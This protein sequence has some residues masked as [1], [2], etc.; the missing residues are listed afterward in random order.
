MEVEARVR[1]VTKDGFYR[2]IRQ[3]LSNPAWT[4][5]E[6]RES[7]AFTL[8]DRSR[9]SRVDRVEAGLAP[10][11]RFVGAPTAGLA[12]LP[13]VEPAGDG[14]DAGSWLEE[15]K[16]KERPEDITI[17]IVA[18][19][20]AAAAEAASEAAGSAGSGRREAAAAGDGR[21]DWR[22]L[23]RL[24]Q[25]RLQLSLEL[26]SSS[27]PP[28][29]DAVAGYEARCFTRLKRRWSFVHKGQVR[30]DVTQ[31]QEGRSMREA[32]SAAPNFEA[33]L[34]W[35]GPHSVKPREA[36]TKLLCKVADVMSL[37]AAGAGG[38]TAPA[39]AREGEAAGR[40]GGVPV[41]KPAAAVKPVAKRTR[42][43][44]EAA[45]TPDVAAA[46]DVAVAPDVA[47]AAPNSESN[48]PDSDGASAPESKKTK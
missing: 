28:S 19:A 7:V 22:E 39:H 33:E 8:P 36:A 32:R 42:P 3:L 31:V 37:L 5:A 38:A 25:V 2:L 15:H 14:H 30:Y 18:E 46:P 16:R 48:E 9:L 45:E 26:P 17:E 43:E 23:R 20:G 44:A 11:A 35:C 34:E 41:V 40:G 24:G 27:K 47:A 29:E 6:Y 4:A 21:S 10:A 12:D 1:G 13:A